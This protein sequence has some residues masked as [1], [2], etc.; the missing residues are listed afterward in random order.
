M[1]SRLITPPDHIKTKKNILIVNATS[2]D[3]T[4]LVLWLKT[5]PDYFDIHL[6]HSQMSET[7]WALEVAEYAET[8]L[9][10]KDNYVDLKSELKEALNSIQ[11]R[12]IYFGSDSNYPDLIQFFLT[13]KELV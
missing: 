11:D 9:V 1:P 8:I 2:N 6:Y 4:T 13:K 3:L 12:V 7:S 5:V 10:S